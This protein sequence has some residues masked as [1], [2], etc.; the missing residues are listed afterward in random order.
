MRSSEV[1][2]LIEI[3]ILCNSITGFRE[4]KHQKYYNI[5]EKNL[6]YLQESK[7]VKIYF[8]KGTMSIVLDKS[9]IIKLV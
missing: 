9:D 1:Q 7:Y 4:N 3:K 6:A 2:S 5:R 8:F